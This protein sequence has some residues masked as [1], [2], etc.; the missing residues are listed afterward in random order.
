APEI[1]AAIVIYTPIDPACTAETTREIARAVSA[2]RPSARNKPVLACVMAQAAG[3]QPLDADGETI[4]TYPFPENAARALGK[5]AA[6]AA[7]RSAPAGL[8]WGFDDLRLD[9]A[10]TVCR[11][12]AEEGGGWLSDEDVWTVLHAM[13]LPAVVSVLARTADEAVAAAGVIGFPVA[14]K[15]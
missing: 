2:A 7:W 12:S 6:D 1:D 11:K 3:R 5:I 14:M 13:G 10:R 9:T 15:L 8:F 4:P